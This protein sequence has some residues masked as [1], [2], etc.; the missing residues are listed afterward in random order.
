MPFVED[1][2]AEWR[3]AYRL[4]DVPPSA[5]SR[6]IRQGQRRLL[7]R[8]H[9]DLFTAGSSDQVEATRMTQVINEAYAKIENAPL[10][11]YDPTR[12][13]REGRFPRTKFEDKP[14]PFKNMERVEFWIKFGLGAAIG[15]FFGLGS[16]PRL[17]MHR[18]PGI[19]GSAA[20]VII[21]MGFFGFGSVKGG[22]KFWDV[23]FRPR[24]RWPW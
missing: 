11:Y 20:I 4:L 13:S 9:P 7:K 3:A 10:R 6:D 16:L 8:W 14:D 19:L 17:Y 15:A 1:Q 21:T 18:D 12:N 23:I 24:W 22:D 5:S 2:L